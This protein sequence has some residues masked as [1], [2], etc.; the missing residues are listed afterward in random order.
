[1]RKYFPSLLSLILCSLLSAQQVPVNTPSAPAPPAPAAATLTGPPQPHTLL[2][3]TPVKLRLSQTISSADAKVGQEI[4]FEVVEEV[5]VDDVVVLPKGATA[6]GTVTECNAKKSMGR[7][8]KLNMNISYA[9]LADQEKVALRATQDNKGG[10]H[11]GAMTGAMVA[12]AVVF[13]P[14]APLFLFIKGKDITIPQGTEI[15]AFVEGDMHL[16]M[17]NF[18]PASAAAAPAAPVSDQASLVIDSAPTGADIVID[19]AFVG[20]TPSTVP[21]AIGDHEIAVQKKGFANWTRKLSVT[22]G[23][24]HLS[25]ELDPVSSPA[26]A[27]AAP[28]AP[29]P[30]AAPPPAPAAT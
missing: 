30:V 7:A 27:P 15:T 6:I 23:S 12:T 9:R 21:V 16:N 1:M 3:G 8:G 24:I 26:Q 19:G 10:G 28:A 13:F 17:A 2:D 29:A 14:A 5:K 22:G 18:A 11:V 25:A 20:N 4:P